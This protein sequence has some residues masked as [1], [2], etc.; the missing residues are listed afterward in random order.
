MTDRMKKDLEEV[1][2]KHKEALVDMI[3]QM[4]FNSDSGNYHEF[5]FSTKTGIMR[6][7]FHDEKGNIF[8]TKVLDFDS[9]SI[10]N[11]IRDL[12]LTIIDF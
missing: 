7:N 8:Y 10:K 1:W 3:D 4:M 5:A 2:D 9:D 12:E 11:D 6:I